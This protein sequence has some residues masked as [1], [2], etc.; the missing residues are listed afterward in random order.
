[1]AWALVSARVVVQILLMV[2]LGIPPLSGLQHFCGDL[3]LVPLLVCLLGDVLRDLLL[4]LV[5]VED[6]AAVLRADIWALAVGGGRVV[7]AVEVLD[8]A[9]VGDLRGVIDDLE[10]FGV[11]RE[12][13]RSAHALASCRITSRSSPQL[14]AGGSRAHSAVARGLGVATN[15]AD[16]GVQQA[17]VSKVFAVHVLDAPEAAG[18]DRALLRA[19]GDVHLR[20]LFGRK[21]QCGGCERSC[22]LLEDRGHCRGAKQREQEIGNAACR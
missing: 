9:A 2:R 18:G 20:S 13:I 8:Q 6:T 21:A 10:R 3:A 7:H 5:V 17:L 22:Q 4:L 1:M 19:F 12:G 11:C 16:A 14:T 15:V